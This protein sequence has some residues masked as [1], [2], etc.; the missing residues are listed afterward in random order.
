VYYRD[1]VGNF[2][3]SGARNGTIFSWTGRG[4]IFDTNGTKWKSGEPSPKGDCVYIQMTNTSANTFLAAE[5]CGEAKKFICEV[6]Y[7]WIRIS[8]IN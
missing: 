7:Y 4:K 2:W 1:F 6:N 3:T 5:N 8:F